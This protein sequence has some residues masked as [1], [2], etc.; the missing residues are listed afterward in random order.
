[1]DQYKTTFSPNYKSD[2]LTQ[3]TSPRYKNL[4]TEVS[5]HEDLENQS[6]K[7]S[8]TKKNTIHASQRKNIKRSCKQD[9]ASISSQISRSSSRQSSIKETIPQLQDI[10][11]NILDGFRNTDKEM[12][13]TSEEEDTHNEEEIISKENELLNKKQQ[14]I[15]TTTNNSLTYND[16]TILLSTAERNKYFIDNHTNMMKLIHENRKITSKDKDKLITTL[17]TLLQTFVEQNLI[18][19]Q[20]EQEIEMNKKLE[21][22]TYAE[23]IATLKKDTNRD[24]INAN[25]EKNEHKQSYVIT[26]KPKNKQ[27]NVKTMRDVKMKINPSKMKINIENVKN[28]SEGGILINTKTRN[29]ILKL[30]EELNKN[31]EITNKYNI[32]I[33][34]KRNPQIK[35]FNVSNDIEPMELKSN[36]IENHNNIKMEEISIKVR[37]KNNNTSNWIMELSPNAYKNLTPEK[38]NIGWQKIYYSEH[39]KP[40]RCFNCSRYGHKGQTCKNKKTCIKCGSTNHDLSK[41]NAKEPNCPNCSFYNIK[42]KTNIP[43]NH[44]SSYNKCHCWKIEQ[45]KIISRTDYG[46]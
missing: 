42:Y 15:I 7:H 18:L 14:D 12:D 43:T 2:N 22:K 17:K 26:I 20:K 31:V 4:I 9:A 19:A 10:D 29:D 27:E 45:K 24:E 33:P 28:I 44:M 39:L 16:S 5:D 35:L 36:I 8:R 38:I 25:T 6:I 30:E 41:C 32:N 23:K 13:C 21:S 40:T 3:N 11:D 34:K 37:H 1:M 46:N